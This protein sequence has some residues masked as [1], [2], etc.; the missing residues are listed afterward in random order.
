MTAV[1]VATRVDQRTKPFEAGLTGP[2]LR[3]VVRNT[4]QRW[5]RGHL[6][7]ATVYVAVLLG[8]VCGRLV[9]L[10]ASGKRGQSL[11]DDGGQ[12]CITVSVVREKPPYSLTL[13]VATSVPPDPALCIILQKR[14]YRDVGYCLV[15]ACLYLLHSAC[16]G[17]ALQLLNFSIIALRLKFGYVIGIGRPTESD[18]HTGIDQH[19]HQALLAWSY[20][21]C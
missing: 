9:E 15:L 12:R 21:V 4:A 10:C 14:P 16:L 6:T 17:G 8:G 19:G 7:V 3:L 13:K 11:E 18:S 20:D 1:G 2:R 5:E